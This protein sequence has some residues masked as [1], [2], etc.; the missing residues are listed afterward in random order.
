M[1]TN[2]IKQMFCNITGADPTDTRWSQLI[3]NGEQL[4]RSRLSVDESSLDTAENSCCEFAAAASAS[5]EYVCIMADKETPVMSE[6]GT[7]G[8]RRSFPQLVSDMK[9]LR[10]SAF[11]VISAA[12]LTGGGFAFTAV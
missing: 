12:G 10:D 5:Y 11:E 8:M 9:K 4:V 7:V 3:I 6:N 2:N 1:T